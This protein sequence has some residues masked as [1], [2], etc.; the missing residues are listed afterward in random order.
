[1]VDGVQFL[2]DILCFQQNILTV[3]I[4]GKCRAIKM[5]SGN[6]ECERPNYKDH[7]YPYNSAPDECGY[8]T[9]DGNECGKPVDKCLCNA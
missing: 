2:L 4:L 3:R 9:D 7:S 5:G 8:E 6:I 1:M